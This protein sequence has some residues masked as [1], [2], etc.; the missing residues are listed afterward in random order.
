[1]IHYV[2]NKLIAIITL[3]YIFVDIN[4]KNNISDPLYEILL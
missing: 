3:I 2:S 4:I 1:M